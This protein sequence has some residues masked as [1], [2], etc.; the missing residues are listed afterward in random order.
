MYCWTKRA[1]FIQKVLAARE[2]FPDSCI[3]VVKDNVVKLSVDYLLNPQRSLEKV[4]WAWCP[5][6]RPYTLP[7]VLGRRWGHV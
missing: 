4:R 7:Q 2:G 5:F 6:W 3:A 1:E